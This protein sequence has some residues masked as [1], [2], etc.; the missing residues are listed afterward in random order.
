MALIILNEL[1]EGS[2]GKSI[3]VEDTTGAF[4]TNNRPGGY[5]A[6]QSPNN[7]RDYTDIAYSFLRIIPPNSEAEDEVFIYIANALAEAMADPGV[8]N[9]PYVVTNTVLQGNSSVITA[10]VY[11]LIYYP[12]FTTME[13]VQNFTFTNGSATVTFTADDLGLDNLSYILV[14]ADG[15]VTAD[16]THHYKVDSIDV[17]SLTLTLDR[18][19][20]GATGAKSSSALVWG[21]AYTNYIAMVYNIN[22][23]ITTKTAQMAI[24]TCGC[25]NNKI[26][27]L[28]Q[29]TQYYFGIS[30]NMDC[31]NYDKAQD[32]IDHL[33][34]YC[35]GT[36]LGGCG[37]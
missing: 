13:N 1:T 29:A 16:A 27:Q 20:T 36:T 23:C 18:V 28:L 37:C 33:N 2:D 14:P 25:K 19:Y 7:K 9:T 31:L 12:C 26:N 6:G 4:D 30:S 5:G 17:D 34:E 32:L 3:T 22:A 11:Q 15:S 21:Y 8:G 35:A 10:G 24:S